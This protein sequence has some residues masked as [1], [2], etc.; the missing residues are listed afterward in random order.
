M[1]KSVLFSSSFTIL[2]GCYIEPRYDKSYNMKQKTNTT[3]KVA[4]VDDHVLIQECLF[5]FLTRWGYSVTIQACN[6][7]DFIEKVTE[8]NMPDIC[9]MEID[10][11][12]LNGYKTIHILKK[13]WPAMKVI[14]LSM[15]ITSRSHID[16]V[17]A[18]AIVS[19][20]SL[21]GIKEALRRHS[22]ANCF[23][24]TPE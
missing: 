23:A 24:A 3:I 17:H 19:K 9:I 15:N 6:G 16:F 2:S 22:P 11:P 10:M 8:D 13:T 18:D 12:V 1:I 4:I 20:L 21:T 14:V 7:K 5:A